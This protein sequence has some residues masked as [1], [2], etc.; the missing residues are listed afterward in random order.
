M[1]KQI[2]NLKIYGG[3]SRV[4]AVTDKVGEG[5]KLK[6]WISSM[7]NDRR[8]ET[9]MSECIL[10]LAIHQDTYCTKSPIHM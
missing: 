5:D 3:D 4:D 8:L 7:M 2:Q 9:W 6:V 10:L 1:S